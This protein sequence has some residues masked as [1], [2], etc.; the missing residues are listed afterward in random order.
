M[1]CRQPPRSRC[2]TCAKNAH[3]CEEAPV[4]GYELLKRVAGVVIKRLQIV[5]LQLLQSRQETSGISART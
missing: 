2:L 5:R 4:F 3:E 1:R